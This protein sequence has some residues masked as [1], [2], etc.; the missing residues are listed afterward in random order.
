MRSLLCVFALILTEAVAGSIP[1]CCQVDTSH[2]TLIHCTDCPGD[3]LALND[4][5]LT[6]IQPNAFSAVGDTITELNLG[7]NNLETLPESVFTG[8]VKLD[9]LVLRCNN[10]KGLPQILLRNNTA[11]RGIDLSF[12]KL[13]LLPGTLFQGLQGLISIIITGNPALETLPSNLF[14]DQHNLFILNLQNNS[15][16][17]IPSSLFMNCPGIKALIME[18]NNL[19]ALPAHVFQPLKHLDLFRIYGNPGTSANNCPSGTTYQVV[20][21]DPLRSFCAYS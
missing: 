2:N 20:C 12:N 14:L 21:R 3:T 11:L 1:S 6:E 13:Q 9:T 7:G 4:L 10:L 8:V 16:A 5:G 15:L 18:D 19:Y 17:S